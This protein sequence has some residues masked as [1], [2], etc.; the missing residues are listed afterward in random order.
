MN[1][2]RVNAPFLLPISTTHNFLKQNNYVFYFYFKV[3]VIIINWFKTKK[4]SI[5][6]IIIIKTDLKRKKYQSKMQKLPSSLPVGAF[7]YVLSVFFGPFRCLLVTC[8]LCGPRAQ[9]PDIVPRR[10]SPV[11]IE[12]V[13]ERVRCLRLNH[14]VWKTVPI[15]HNS[16]W[17]EILPQHQPGFRLPELNYIIAQNN[18]KNR[19]T[20]SFFTVVTMVSD[21]LIRNV[22]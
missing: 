8:S 13:F 6:I 12:S 17:E 15:I 7:C 19:I 21:K 1:K 9:G 10:F 11:F 14:S 4:I 16:L 22:F 18:C 3:L 2:I 20:D 5:I